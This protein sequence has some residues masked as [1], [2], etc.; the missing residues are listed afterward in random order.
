MA[1]GYNPKSSSVSVE[2]IGNK[3]NNLVY[4]TLQFPWYPAYPGMQTTIELSPKGMTRYEDGTLPT[5]P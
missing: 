3:L 5:E 1:L 4:W 2:Y